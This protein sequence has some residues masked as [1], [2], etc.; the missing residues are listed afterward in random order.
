M[1]INLILKWSIQAVKKNSEQS[2]FNANSSKSGVSSEKEVKNL[3]PINVNTAS[4]LDIRERGF[5]VNLAQRIIYFRELN[6]GISNW[7]Q[8]DSMYGFGAKTIEK[9]QTKLT[10]K[11]VTTT[12]QKFSLNE[13]N[14]NLWYAMGLSRKEVK[15]ILEY[16]NQNGKLTSLTTLETLLSSEKMIEI[17]NHIK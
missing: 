5:S 10:L 13:T 12:P 3:G 6:G 11:T 2:V 14:E 4:Y 17:K 15:A 8:L 7:L 9:L 16:E 1:K